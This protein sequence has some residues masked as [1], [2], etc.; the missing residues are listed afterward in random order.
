MEKELFAQALG[1][2]K[3]WEITKIDFKSDGGV[4]DRG[5]MNIYIDWKKGSRFPDDE[6][7]MCGVHDTVAKTYRHIDFFQHECFLH[8]RIPRIKTSSG[9]V[10]TV[11]VPWARKGSQF[12]LQFESYALTL[13]GCEMPVNRVAKILNV[14]PNR[15]WRILDFYVHNS[16]CEQDYSEVTQLGIDEKSYRKGHKYLT[17][18]S[19]LK[20]HRVIHVSPGRSKDNIK[21]IKDFIGSRQVP[22][23]QIT[24]ICIDPYP[25]YIGG[26]LEHFESSSIT[27]DKY[28]IK[29]LL[30]VAM[31][32]IRR[33][34]QRENRELKRTR[35]LWL[36]NESTLTSKQQS[37][38][39]Y[40]S[41]NYP[42]IGKAYRL[43]LSFDDLWQCKTVEQAE[44]FLNDW[45]HEASKLQ[46]SYLDQFVHTMYVHWYGVIQYFQSRI[47][48]GIVESI[49]QK[50]ALAIRRARGFRNLHNLSNMIYLIAGKLTFNFH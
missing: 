50:I 37:K 27:F 30:N 17:V 42:T 36:R 18:C 25:A 13:V 21:R 10:Q 22:S 7:E 49:N 11:K 20:E 40:L 6:G 35:Y 26:V 28:H 39:N 47:S 31:D 16:R 8:C 38:L 2:T 12:T 1:L 48:N 4:F 23:D 45:T 34:E 14:Y 3:S 9:S 46:I 15:I 43:K 5:V 19:D 24:D 33:A 29:R 44:E 32:K 41:I